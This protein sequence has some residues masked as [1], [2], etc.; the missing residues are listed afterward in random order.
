MFEEIDRYWKER[1]N[2]PILISLAK[3]IEASLHP[4]PRIIAP[5]QMISHARMIA[6]LTNDSITS[7]S[8]YFVHC[9]SEMILITHLLA[10][11]P[12]KLSGRLLANTCHPIER[13]QRMAKGNFQRFEH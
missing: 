4:I 11:E 13:S 8:V 7:K 1:I 6:A 9:T 5:T 12:E 2:E 3:G 10:E